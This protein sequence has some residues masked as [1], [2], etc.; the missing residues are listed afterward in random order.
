[1]LRRPPLKLV[2]LVALVVAAFFALNATIEVD[3]DDLERA[4]D[5]AGLLGPIVYA[6][7][8]TLGLTVPMNPVSDLLTVTVASVVLDPKA[9][10]VATA[11]AQS[12]AVTVNYLVGYR[13]GTRLLDRVLERR[14][15]P[16]VRRVRD[17]ITVRA[18]FLLR[19]AL[20]LT[21]IGI[22]WISY[23]AGAQRLRFGAYFVAS[24]VPWT[25]M[26]VIF[27][28]SAALLRETSPFLVLLPAVGLIVL[29]SLLVFILRRHTNILVPS[30]GTP[31]GAV[32]SEVPIEVTSEVRSGVPPRR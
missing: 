25:V 29:A 18:I 3:Q 14:E 27:F 22:D 24:T 7:I 5:R 28:V 19:F 8:L 31:V 6:V 23:L 17:H 2:A 10:I 30:H 15:I 1:M 12:I 21:A 20:P 11:I 26:S 16:L 4:I 9:A 32:P 13:Y